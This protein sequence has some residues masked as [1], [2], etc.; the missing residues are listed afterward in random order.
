[1]SRHFQCK[2]AG[3]PTVLDVV[4]S[5]ALGAGSRA[6]SDTCPVAVAK[7]LTR[8]H[9]CSKF[10]G[11][12]VSG[13]EV[14]AARTYGCPILSPVGGREG[15]LHS[16]SFLLRHQPWDAHSSHSGQVFP[17]HITK[18]R[19]SLADTPRGLPPGS[20]ILDHWFSTCVSG[21]S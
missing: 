19:K 14:A 2:N 21:P 8:A 16:A 5:L 13:K 7:C 17:L 3:S 11:I 9:L 12:Q 15:R 20:A 6:V 18:S 10:S 4:G 1:M